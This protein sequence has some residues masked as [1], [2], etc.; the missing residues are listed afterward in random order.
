MSPA[1]RLS[2]EIL[3]PVVLLLW[4]AWERAGRGIAEMEARYARNDLDRD[5]RRE[6]MFW[7]NV[8]GAVVVS[9]GVQIH[10]A[11]TQFDTVR[12]LLGRATEQAGACLDGTAS[13]VFVNQTDARWLIEQF[14]LA[15]RA[16]ARD[17][18]VDVM[19]DQIHQAA[20]GPTSP[21]RGAA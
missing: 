2:L 3:V 1:I 21:D 5:R 19:G 8:D 10:V 12:A 11:W 6:V 4:V 7:H 9:H 18:P 15:E 17:T 14:S 13:R 16:R 20:R